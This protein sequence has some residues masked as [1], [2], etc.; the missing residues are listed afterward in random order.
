MNDGTLPRLTPQSPR[1]VEDEL[2]DALR[3][4]F[5]A[6]DPPALTNPASLLS[7]RKEIEVVHEQ[8][9][10]PLIVTKRRWITWILGALLVAATFL[11]YRAYG[12]EIDNFSDRHVRLGDIESDLQALTR[13]EWA[14][15]IQAANAAGRVC[16]RDALYAALRQRFGGRNQTPAGRWLTRSRDI[17]YR[18]PDLKDSVYAGL[19]VGES[20]VLPLGKI[21]LGRVVRVGAYDIGVDKLAHFWSAGYQYFA[22]AYLRPRQ[23]DVSKA[24]ELGRWM[25]AGL[26]GYT[27]TGVYSYADLSANFAGMRFWNHVL[28]EHE[29]PLGEELG[30]YVACR[31]GHWVSLKAPVWSDYMD[32]SWDEAVNCSAFHLSTMRE[33]IER[34]L[35]AMSRK[36]GRKLGCPL[37]H[38]HDPELRR[39]YGPYFD[40]LVNTRGFTDVVHLP[41]LRP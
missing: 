36:S 28:S 32:I 11:S 27:V 1:Q 20:R 30:P 9:V 12:S 15:A 39:K 41:S 8:S 7:R 26:F 29:D 21:A 33:K 31:D 35:A 22:H 3:S 10:H 5:P 34:N 14:A 40:E 19:N 13:R 16:S 18:Q 23:P 38:E 37:T 24:L 17:P 4:S 25:E 2:D 6:S